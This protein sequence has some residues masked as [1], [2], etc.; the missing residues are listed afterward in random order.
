M[1]TIEFE[2]NCDIEKETAELKRELEEYLQEIKKGNLDLDQI[3]RARR[4]LS[5]V[6]GILQ[7]RNLEVAQSLPPSV[8]PEFL[9]PIS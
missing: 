7:I 3:Y 1:T 4:A 2:E 6:R 8:P 5:L 9:C